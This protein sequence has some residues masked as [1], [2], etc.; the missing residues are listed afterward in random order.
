MGTQMF[1]LSFNWRPADGSIENHASADTITSSEPEFC[2]LDDLLRYDQCLVLSG[3][4]D[5]EPCEMHLTIT[6]LYL[7][8]GVSIIA[9]CPVV[10]VYYGRLREYNRTVHGELLYTIVDGHV[11]RYDLSIETETSELHVKFIMDDPSEPVSLYTTHLYLMRNT[12]PLRAMRMMMAESKLINPDA[13]QQRLQGATLSERAERC[14]HLILGSMLSAQQNFENNNAR[15]SSI[16]AAAAGSMPL[17][18]IDVAHSNAQSSVEASSP[19]NHTPAA[20]N[21]GQPAAAAASMHDN[22]H[23]VNNNVQSS[24][25]SGVPLSVLPDMANLA[26]SVANG[27]IETRI[28]QYIDAKFVQLEHFVDNRLADLAARQDQKLDRLLELL[29]EQRESAQNGSHGS[30]A[31]QSFALQ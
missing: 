22:I 12:D 28:K 25:G 3:S 7:V 8:R 2:T 19:S 10:E 21:D 30:K 4:E 14:K 27:N 23:A 26:L 18:N 20:N 9:E 17:D 16:A 15:L 24:A 31:E 11:Y 13:V 5:Q 6:P 1:R 29:Q